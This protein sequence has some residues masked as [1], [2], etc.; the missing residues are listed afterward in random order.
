MLSSSPILPIKNHND[1]LHN[2]NTIIETKNK[3]NPNRHA[4]K[5]SI[6]TK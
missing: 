6:A 1:K 3:T 4:E 5:I 2:H